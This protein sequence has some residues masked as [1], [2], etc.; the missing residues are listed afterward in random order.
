[1]VSGGGCGGGGGVRILRRH[2][3]ER[4]AA[5]LAATAAVLLL[6][7]SVRIARH[8]VAALRHVRRRADAGRA[9][10]MVRL[11]QFEKGV[12]RGDGG[13][14]GRRRRC[15]R[16]RRLDLVAVRPATAADDRIGRRRRHVVITAAAAEM[17]V[18]ETVGR[19]G[20]RWR[21]RRIPPDLMR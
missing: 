2:V 12:F 7:L 18:D 8:A 9:G 14:G 21:C 11:L 13:C 17:T 1:M 6:H 4:V 5:Q 3:R 20:R 15:R 16:R 19:T 10:Q